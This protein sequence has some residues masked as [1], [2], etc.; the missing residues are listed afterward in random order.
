MAAVAGL[1][2]LMDSIYTVG[3]K[4][5]RLNFYLRAKLK[6]RISGAVWHLVWWIWG[7]FR[8]PGAVAT[9]IRADSALIRR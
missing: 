6:C 5:W 1:I 8:P 3:V 9:E 7:G 4:Y 2:H